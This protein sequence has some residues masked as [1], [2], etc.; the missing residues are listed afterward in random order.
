MEPAK[1]LGV[2]TAEAP[3]H[4]SDSIP[5]GLALSKILRLEQRNVELQDH[6]ERLTAQNHQLAE[7]LRVQVEG[8]QMQQRQFDKLLSRKESDAQKLRPPPSKPMGD[9]AI[10]H[11]DPAGIDRIGP[12][13][14]RHKGRPD[15][16]NLAE[17]RRDVFRS[18]LPPLALP[19]VRQ[20]A[21]GQV[22]ISA[23]GGREHGGQQDRR[24]PDGM[25]RHGMGRGQIGRE[26]ASGLHGMGLVDAGEHGYRRKYVGGGAARGNV[27]AARLPPIMHR[28]EPFPNYKLQAKMAAARYDPKVERELKA[29]Q[30]AEAAR[31]T[32]AL[33]LQEQQRARRLAQLYIERQ[34]AAAKREP[35]A[36]GAESGAG[37]PGEA[38]PL[39]QNLDEE[40][41]DP[42]SDGKGRSVDVGDA[43]PDAGDAAPDAGSFGGEAIIE[44][45][46]DSAGGTEFKGSSH[47]QGGADGRADEEVDGGGNGE[48]AESRASGARAEEGTKDS[49][50]A[51]PEGGEEK[52]GME[53]GA[54][55]KGGGEGEDQSPRAEHGGKPKGER[56]TDRRDPTRPV[57]GAARANAARSKMR[58]GRGGARGI[59]ADDGKRQ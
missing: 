5:P 16:S 46:D 15:S 14:P 27:A 21:E 17:P 40:A 30:I 24:G 44:C 58:R 38:G 54:D 32:K 23:M 50:D 20:R 4:V 9:D 55:G 26:A 1:Q 49:R 28:V 2:R 51:G 35:A 59:D 39:M 42:G 43:A 22:A 31:R 8:M 52:D 34:A 45:R 25:G 11:Q 19:P 48:A 29:A 47:G 13:S 3:H 53:V 18:T 57:R 41:D 12:F 56:L 6:V 36:L 33:R 37:D 7:A 10:Q